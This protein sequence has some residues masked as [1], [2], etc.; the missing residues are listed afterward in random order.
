LLGFPLITPSP[1]VS[2]N[3]KAFWLELQ[4]QANARDLA[5]RDYEVETVGVTTVSTV[6]LACVDA[7]NHLLGIVTRQAT[8]E[9]NSLKK[10]SKVV[11]VRLF[12]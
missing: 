1:Q 2:G 10:V 7:N 12:D 3:V 4:G 9:G 11:P 5:S 6:S 8:Y